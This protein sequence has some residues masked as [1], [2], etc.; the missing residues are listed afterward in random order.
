[1]PSPDLPL[2]T[3]VLPGF[4]AWELRNDGTLWPAAV[5]RHPWEAGVNHARCEMGADHDAPAP[6]C[7]CG[8]Y[9][10]HTVHRQ[11]SGESV[12]GAIAAWGAM[13]VHADGFRA[14]RARVIALAAPRSTFV[15]RDAFERAAERYDVPVV[16]RDVFQQVVSLSTGNLPPELVAIAPADHS[17][18]LAHRRGFDADNQVW[19]EASQGVVTVGLSPHLR[20]RL[21]EGPT[22]IEQRPR[23]IAV[24]GDLLTV[25][26]P[27][28]VR[29]EIVATGDGWLRIR[30]SDWEAD[31]RHF[32]WGPVGMA[33]MDAHALRNGVDGVAHLLDGR[34]AESGPASWREVLAELRTRREVFAGPRFATDA[35]LYDEIA[36]PLG[37]A[38]AR[39]RSIRTRLTRLGAVV[40]FVINEPDARIVLDLREGPGVLFCGARG[41]APD[42]EVGVTGADLVRVLAGRIDLAQAARAEKIDVRGDFAATLTALAV[43]G[44]WARDHLPTIAATVP[45]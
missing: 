19:V 24:R 26:I 18:W 45:A 12:I 34:A 15:R 25:H 28:P 37:Q 23:T 33:A 44:R 35:D 8:L 38:L 16:D 13:E 42:T 36:I 39:D 22:V 1:V 7:S 27:Q 40:A 32:D 6:D 17:K 20:G 4:R 3:D 5:A 29:G 41:P 21:G 9:A 31:C 10:F 2:L 43:V 30:P 11:L 14:A